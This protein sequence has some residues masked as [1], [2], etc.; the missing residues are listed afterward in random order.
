[1]RAHTRRRN[2]AS[3]PILGVRTSAEPTIS[4]TTRIP[5]SNRKLLE[6]STVGVPKPRLWQACKLPA[7]PS[8]EAIKARSTSGV[9]AATVFIPTDR[10]TAPL[11]ARL[12]VLWLSHLHDPSRGSAGRVWSTGGMI[13]WCC[14]Q[15]LADSTARQLLG[16]HGRP[17]VDFSGPRRQRA[18]VRERTRAAGKGM[19][20]NSDSR[21]ARPAPFRRDTN[22]RTIKSIVNSMF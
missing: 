20:A 7:R 15:K 10:H 9:Q 1:M 18:A 22:T 13:I 5:L 2:G 11:E 4:T 21:P 17:V 12:Q 3:A 19:V 6:R 8:L 14:Q 16:Y